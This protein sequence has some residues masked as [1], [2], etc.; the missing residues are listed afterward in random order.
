MSIL[1]RKIDMNVLSGANGLVRMG[2]K[3]FSDVH[4]VP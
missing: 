3:N 4:S 2:E 1:R